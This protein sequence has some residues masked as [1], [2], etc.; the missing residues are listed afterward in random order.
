VAVAPA[1]DAA[2]TQAVVATGPGAAAYRDGLQAWHDG[3]TEAALRDL[4]QAVSLDRE[5]GAAQL[6]LALWRF[7]LAGAPAGK[8]VE[9]REHY[10]AALLHRASM[11]EVDKGLL[12]AAEPY[13]RQP[14]DLHDWTKRLEELSKK[15]PADA[16]LLYYLGEAHQLHLT[17]DAA[18]AAYDRALAID[19]T[20]VIAHVAEAESLAMKG[21]VEGQLRA[22]RTCL[23]TS[24]QATQCLTKQLTL[25]AQVG[26]CVAMK[27]D[28][29][30]LLS[31]DPKSPDAHRQLALALSA[32][33]SSNE[34]VL[35]AFARSWALE[36]SSD[37]KVSELQDR[38]SMAELGGD[39]VGAEPSLVDWLAAVADKPNQSA[40]IVPSQRLAELYTEMGLPKKASDAADAFLRKMNAWTEQATGDPTLLFLSYRLRAGAISREEYERARTEAIEK[41]RNKWTGAGRKIDDDFAWLSWS[42]A[43]GTEVVTADE[44]RAAVDAM[45]KTASKAVESGRWPAIDLAAGKT[46]ALVGQHEH[47]LTPLK[48]I[49]SPCLS[50]V[51]PVNRIGADFYLGM[52]LEST[53]D[54]DGARTS[55]RRVLE[56]W[57]E[58]KPRSVTEEQAK[59]RLHALGEK[60]K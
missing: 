19:P 2:T 51:D 16:E 3:A 30:R 7:A 52:A 33:G 28:A 36:P 8:Q 39:F 41:F 15:Y 9:G 6:R 11:S 50:L 25:R 43:Y 26:R 1:S 45:P 42:M 58:A 34:S 20:L 38:T 56:H 10:Q 13:M 32:T 48:R 31:I 47:A 54:T 14:W 53:G 49:G 46:Y 21:D 22:Y 29:Q 44:A 57:G 23:E 40:H 60:K 37:R 24:P 18:I 27:T 35:E 4:E 59:K 17:P 5:L 55:Y 12:A